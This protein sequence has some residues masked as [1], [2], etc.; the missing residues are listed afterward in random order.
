MFGDKNHVVAIATAI[1]TLG[2]F[3]A[4]PEWFNTLAKTSI[5]NI[6]M[7]SVLVYQ[8]GGNLD[9][10]YSLVVATLFYLVVHLTKYVEIGASGVAE[11]VHGEMEYPQYLE[12]ETAPEESA[13]EVNTM[14]EDGAESFMG[15]Y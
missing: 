11:E 10:V 4:A 15:Y 8:G 14:E 2:G 12:E 7:G 3:Q 1:G 13:P 9:Y 6:L 5:W